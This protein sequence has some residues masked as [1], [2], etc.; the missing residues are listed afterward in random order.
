MITHN[1]MVY[2]LSVLFLI[3]GL[4][5]LMPLKIN[6]LYRQIYIAIGIV[7]FLIAGFRGAGVDRDYIQY[8]G[9][10]NHFN[11]VLVEPSFVFISFV[12]NKYFSNN[13]L[14]LFIVFA[15]LGVVI[16]L[17]AIKVLSEL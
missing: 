12:I 15:C 11:T 5:A 1:F 9:M 16:K 14:Y 17:H 13:V 7:L 8:V 2:I 4:L 10:F 3:L 6:R